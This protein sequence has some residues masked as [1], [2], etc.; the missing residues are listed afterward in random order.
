MPEKFEPKFDEGEGR[1]EIEQ[2]P[3]ESETE[4]EEYLVLKDREIR[5]FYKNW[6]L[7]N[8]KII[9]GTVE[10]IGAER[11][12][13]GER[14]FVRFEHPPA[15]VVLT[16]TSGVPFGYAFKEG[17]KEAFPDKPLPRFLRINVKPFKSDIDFIKG[18]STVESEANSRWWGSKEYFRKEHGT[19]ENLFNNLNNN[20][21]RAQK[22]FDNAVEQWKNKIEKFKLHSRKIAVF[23]EVMRFG[24]TREAAVYLLQ[25][26]GIPRENIVE[27]FGVTGGFPV[28]RGQE[29]ELGGRSPTEEQL[30]SLSRK[31]KIVSEKSKIQQAKNL[32]HDM[33]LLGKEA[34]ELLKKELEEEHSK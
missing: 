31:T 7:H 16:E 19:Y 9:G 33:K 5:G 11:G 30:E 13:T 6:I 3:E 32:I 4:K 28:W 8:L 21:Q 24:L 23:D 15:V 20:Y 26:A 27:L 10:G 25:R 1:E 18:K 34:G 17:F 14:E 2:K 22:A 29:E 12:D